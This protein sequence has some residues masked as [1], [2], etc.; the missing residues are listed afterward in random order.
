M[1]TAKEFPNRQFKSNEELFKELK[2][3]KNTL[4]AQKKMITKFT[5]SF[6][7][8]HLLGSEKSEAEKSNLGNQS[9]NKIQIKSAINTVGIYDSHGDVSVSG[10]WNKTAKE[11]KNILLLQE[12]KMTF[13][14]IISDEVEVGVEV[15]SWKNLGFDYAGKTE[16]LMFNSTISKDRNPFMFDQYL[17]GYV[18]EHSAGLRY[19]KMDLAFNSEVE[20]NKEE[21][22]VWDKYFPQIVNKEEAEEKGYFWAVIEQKIIEGSAVVKGSNFATPTISIEAVDDTSK[23]EPT[24]VTQNHVE[25]KKFNVFIKI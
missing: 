16:V 2:T 20:W 19:V 11:A 7:Y 25:E 18:K 9:P 12:H 21:K 6:S 17:K 13:D 23:S 14:K 4:I 24:N 1:I 3:H 22:A 10:S 15:I 5:D 8:V